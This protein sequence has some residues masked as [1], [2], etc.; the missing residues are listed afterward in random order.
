MPV[1]HTHGVQVD[2]HIFETDM[3]QAQRCDDIEAL[4]TTFDSAVMPRE[5]E[6]EIH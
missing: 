1:E 3:L 6:N 5:H 2:T 4:Q